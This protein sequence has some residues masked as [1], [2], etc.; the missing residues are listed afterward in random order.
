[1]AADVPRLPRRTI[2]I[3]GSSRTRVGEAEYEAAK[4]LGTLLA[5]RGWTI[6]NG[7]NEGTME[8]SARGAKEA[9]GRTIG[10]SIEQYRPATPNRWLDEEVVAETLFIRLEKLVTIADAFVVLRGGI[11]TLLELALAWNLIQSP[12]FSHKPLVV[13]GANWDAILAAMRAHLPMHPW[14]ANSLAVV[15]TVDEAVE[16]LAERLESAAPTQD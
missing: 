9:G 8:A 4:R 10:I 2:T 7:G 1:M 3:F 6:C 11:G 14:E 5:K 12:Q 13:V 15:E 16:M